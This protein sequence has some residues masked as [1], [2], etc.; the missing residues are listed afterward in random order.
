MA[1][2]VPAVIVHLACAHHGTEVQVDLVHK[3]VR[4]SVPFS[5]SGAK[6]AGCMLPN[7]AHQVF[8]AENPDSVCG[9]Q[10]PWDPRRGRALCHISVKA[11]R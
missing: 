1:E 7:V 6:P 9:A 5:R 3:A 8:E 10:G 2:V 4:Q 11:G